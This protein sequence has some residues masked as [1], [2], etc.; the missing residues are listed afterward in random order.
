M[1]MRTT[2]TFFGF[3]VLAQWAR[4][5]YWRHFGN[6]CGSRLHWSWVRINKRVRCFLIYMLSEPWAASAIWNGNQWETE[7]SYTW[8][9]MCLRRSGSRWQK[10][11]GGSI[12]VRCK[13]RSKG[14]WGDESDELWDRDGRM[15]K[16]K[17]R[18]WDG[19]C[20]WEC[21]FYCWSR[22]ISGFQDL[23]SR[24]PSSVLMLLG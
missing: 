8:W 19:Y 10:C 6:F 20:A 13:G 22:W 7:D 9:G 16:K 18:T 12:G 15:R 17:V 3:G 1:N 14:G 2:F 11:V 5:I 21:C 4:W 24:S 23:F